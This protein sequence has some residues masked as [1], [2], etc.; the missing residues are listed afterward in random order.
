MEKSWLETPTS[1]SDVGVFRPPP[2]THPSRILS[3]FIRSKF[4]RLFSFLIST[5]AI[6]H[7]LDMHA[8]YKSL[9]SLR[10]AVR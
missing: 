6:G 9:D 4:Y 8:Q 10:H 7:Q 3:I 1:K 2:P 5:A